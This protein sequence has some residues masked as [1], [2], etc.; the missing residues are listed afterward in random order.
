MN[1]QDIIEKLRLQEEGLHFQ[2]FNSID[3]WELGNALVDI[4]KK[5]GV[6][7]SIS[8]RKI[9]GYIMFQYAFE[10]TTEFNAEWLERKHNTVV[11]TGRS[12][13]LMHSQIKAEEGHADQSQPWF[14]TPGK[15]S[16]YGGGFPIIVDGMGMVATVCVSGLDHVSDHNLIIEGLISHS[17][18]TNIPNITNEDFKA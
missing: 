5:N 9:S 15:Y 1:L 13:L 11:L 10:D 4:A 8:I 6:H 3:A 18:R 16:L 2:R 7:V 14:L 12:T 17:G